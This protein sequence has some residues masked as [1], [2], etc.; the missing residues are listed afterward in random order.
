MSLVCENSLV[1]TMRVSTAQENLLTSAYTV[2]RSSGV[3]RTSLGRRLFRSAYF[4]YKRYIEDNLHDLVRAHPVLPEGGNVLDIG[5]NI[6]YTSSI[7]A[8]AIDADCKVYAFEPE[9]FNYALLHQL[10]S[11]PEFRSKIIAQQ[12]AVGAENGTVELWLNDHHHADHLVITSAF[13]AA[14]STVSSTS[15]PILTVDSFL[16]RN[17]GPVSLVKI[18]VQGYELPVC[19]GM[20][21]TLEKNDDIKIVLEYSP[22]GMRSLGFDPSSLIKFL[23]DRGFQVYLV[24]SKGK[25]TP[26][27]PTAM[28]QHGYVDLLFSRKPMACRG[29]P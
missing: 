12:C 10:A 9:P 25:L 4:L 3:L 13:R 26:G 15:V 23:L 1:S 8:R 22:S 7:L 29:G 27:M 17:P 20:Q 6:G 24:R 28:G 19:Q 5:A 11:R 14:N 18:D 21:R 16:D 2:L